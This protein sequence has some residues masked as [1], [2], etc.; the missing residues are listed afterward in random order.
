MDRA[1]VLAI[2]PRGNPRECGMPRLVLT[3]FHVRTRARERGMSHAETEKELRSERYPFDLVGR[4]GEPHEIAHA[5]LFLASSESAYATGA[6]FHI[7]GGKG[8][9]R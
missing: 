5:L 9:F 6:V 2:S 3:R 7:D 4:S 8:V 1:L